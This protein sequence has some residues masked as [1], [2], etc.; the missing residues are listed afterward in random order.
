M[1]ATAQRAERI[2]QDGL[3]LMGY[4]YYANALACFEQAIDLNPNFAQA[5]F[6]IGHCRSE[7]VQRE[8]ENTDEYLYANEMSERYQGAI[9]AYQK[10]IELQP[11]YADARSSLAELFFDFGESQSEESEYPSD[12]M[13][14]IKW[15]KQAIE[16]D[17]DWVVAYHQI[18]ETY[19]LLMENFSD[20]EIGDQ[21]NFNGTLGIAEECI[22]TYQQFIEVHP[23]DAGAY[24]ELGKA[25]MRWI[26]PF[27]TMEENYG[28]ETSDEIEAMKQDKHPEIQGVLKKRDKS[29]SHSRK[30]QVLTM[31]T[32]YY[33]L[34]EGVSTSLVNLRKRSKLSNKPLYLMLKITL[35]LPTGTSQKRTTV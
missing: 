21:I 22:E 28:D 4:R 5:W 6:Q 17:H 33:K 35:R 24:Y 3:V 11:D 34:A 9:E 13:R 10:V 26:D 15:Y 29:V 25:Y 7:L 20:Y 14:A 1:N 32:A 31:G 16:L 19:S 27:I 8:V 23:N 18:G 2:Y 30:N 12:Y